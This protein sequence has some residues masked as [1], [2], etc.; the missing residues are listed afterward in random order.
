M[1]YTIR[2]QPN[3]RLFKVYSKSG[4]P[5]SKKGLPLKTA[6]RQKIAA[7]LSSLNIERRR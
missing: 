4:R 5:L 2:K 1:P 3:K 6:Q 7:T